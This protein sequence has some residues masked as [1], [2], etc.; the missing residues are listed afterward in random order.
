M[1]KEHC[2]SAKWFIHPNSWSLFILS[3]TFPGKLHLNRQK[4]TVACKA[5]E[6]VNAED[7]LKHQFQIFL[8]FEVFAWFTSPWFVWE[9][10]W[11]GRREKRKL[12]LSR[13]RME[14]M[15]VEFQAY[16]DLQRRICFSNQGNVLLHPSSFVPDLNKTT[17]FWV[18]EIGFI[19]PGN[20][21]SGL[22]CRAWFPLGALLLRLQHIFEFSVNLALGLSPSPSSYFLR[23][24]GWGG[25]LL[26]L[27][28]ES[29]HEAF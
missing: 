9:S 22:P 28:S 16:E 6:T 5:E 8:V 11:G 1:F 3:L 7:L 21:F 19:L 27:K 14:K 29:W 13:E 4:G 26:T 17:M 25:I 24:Q 12:Y 18:Q 2:T 10:S 20:T 15:E 23:W